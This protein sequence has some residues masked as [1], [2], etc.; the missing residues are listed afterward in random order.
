ML[1]VSVD[2]VWGVWDASSNITNL[3]PLGEK[4]MNAIATKFQVAAAA[5]AMAG[6][7][8]FA[9]IA[10]NAAP[11]VQISAAPV[12]QAAGNLA[13]APGDFIWYLQVSSLQN[14]SFL[15][16]SAVFWTDTAINNYEARLAR[17]PS[18]PF[19]AYY[20]RRIDA[21]QERR[22]Q[23]GQVSASICRN[24]QGVSVGPYGTFTRGAC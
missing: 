1:R 16:R 17:N 8:V 6:A 19:A 4:Q 18:S 10:A 13:Q 24:G 9:P 22:A 7:A 20:Q 14:T 2:R 5:T 15:T 11:A 21:L 23:Y 12:Q 3:E